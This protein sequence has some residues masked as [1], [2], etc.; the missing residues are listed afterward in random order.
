MLDLAL[1]SAPLLAYLTVGVVAA[2]DLFVPVLP[3]GTLLITGGAL[4]AQGELTVIGL[5]AFGVVGAWAGDLGGY[6]LG[7]NV[8]RGLAHLRHSASAAP[9][10]PRVAATSWQARLLRHSVLTLIAARYLPAGR[11][12]AAV[13]AGRRAYPWRRYA[14]SAL[15]AETLW[16]V[17]AVLLGYL[18]GQFIP[19]P[20]LVAFGLTTLAVTVIVTIVR[21]LRGSSGP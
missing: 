7:R 12:V 5:M 17:P 15:A 9:S 16:A 11:T 4:A 19:I 13:T 14:L 8:A 3:S 21:R 2:L 18:G 10:R 20:L 1:P 6:R